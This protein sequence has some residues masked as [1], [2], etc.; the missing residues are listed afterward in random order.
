M[1]KYLIKHI[2][3]KTLT[4]R[5]VSSFLTEYLDDRLDTDTRERFEEH[6]RYCN[7]C[8]AYLNQFRITIEMV[9]D[10]QPPPPP[11]ELAEHTLEFLSRPLDPDS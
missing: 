8:E 11:P 7:S 6:L 3:G 2:L 5:D 4:C 10:D 1:I 9:R